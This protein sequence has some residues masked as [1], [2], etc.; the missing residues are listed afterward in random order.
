MSLKTSSTLKRTL[1]LCLNVSKTKS[2]Q[3]WVYFFRDCTVMERLGNES[4]IVVSI[5]S[6]GI[7]RWSR[8]V[9]GSTNYSGTVLFQCTC[10]NPHFR[11]RLECLQCTDN[12]WNYEA[13]KPTWITISWLLKWLN[14]D[15][16]CLY[17]MSVWLHVCLSRY[18]DEVTALK[19]F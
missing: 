4:V 12:P 17:G 9:T 10:T 7:I 19:R 6:T 13:N 14:L 18:N 3:T 15:L 1:C 11:Q 5:Y 8:D 16:I 2:W